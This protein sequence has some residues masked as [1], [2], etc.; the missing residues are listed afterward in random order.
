MLKGVFFFNF[1]LEKLKV[2]V[3]FFNDSTPFITLYKNPFVLPSPLACW[4][5][6]LHQQGNLSDTKM[7][8]IS[9][10]VIKISCSIRYVALLHTYGLLC[11]FVVSSVI[12]Y[13]F[14]VFCLYFRYH[15]RRRKEPKETM[16]SFFRKSQDSKKVTV[17]EREADGFV[18]V[19]KWCFCIKWFFRLWNF[20]LEVSLRCLD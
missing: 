20:D 4:S 19:G 17:P 2:W 9:N 10:W 6:L 3:F 15:L 11:E 1:P 16:F 13:L 7:P 8:D 12:I 14:N 5:K 18:I